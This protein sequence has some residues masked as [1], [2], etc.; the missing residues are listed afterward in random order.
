M[1]TTRFL[2]LAGLLGALTM[3]TGDMLFYGGWGSGADLLANL[4]S[5]VAARSPNQLMAGGLLAIPAGL[6]FL[7]GA[8]H[9][10]GRVSPGWRIAVTAPL[11]A[12]FVA[13]IA[14]HAIW[15]AFA[16]ALATGS[17]ALSAVVGRYLDLCFLVA[18]VLA[19]PAALSLLIACVLGRTTWP[20]W[21]SLA[22][23]TLL[24]LVLQGA[25]WLPAPLGAPL[26]GGAFNLAFALFF[27]LSLATSQ[28]RPAKA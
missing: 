4:P 23:P 11:L 22:N 24:Y 1:T 5:Q 7:G 3:F 14:T 19:V 16:I 17:H 25:R 2:A 21:M 13:A 18:T 9:V 27:T 10:Y 8:V 6:G 20:R 15:G 28:E 12:L 26:L